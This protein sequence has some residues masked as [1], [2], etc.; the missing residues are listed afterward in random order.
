M[1]FSHTP[2][3]RCHKAAGQGIV[4]LNGHD[5]YLGPWPET[6]RKP[7]VHVKNA[8]DRLIA[9]W[10]ANGRQLVRQQNVSLTVA[11]I[12][13][14]FWRHVEQHYRRSD[15]TATHEVV[16]YRNSLRPVAHLYGDLPADEF[17][18]LKLKAVR[19]LMIH[20][21][22]H[23]KYGPQPPLSRANINQRIGRI[24]RCVKWAVGSGQRTG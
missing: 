7:P 4:T 17:S 5:H 15:G 3:L 10:Y 6:T 22:K 11:E 20:G 21:Y 23:P 18:P 9:E 14:R 1:R 19:D 2:A 16:S 8:Y 24:V 12:I 13:E